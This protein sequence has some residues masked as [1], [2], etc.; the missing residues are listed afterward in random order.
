MRGLPLDD[1][2]FEPSMD[3]FVGAAQGAL[4][5]MGEELPADAAW[6]LSGL[7]FGAQVHRTL[8]PEGLFPRAWD[9]T[10]TKV[11]E[12]FGYGCIAGLRDFFYTEDDISLLRSGWMRNIRKHLDEGLPAIAF[13]LHGPAFGIVHGFDEDKEAYLVSTRFDGHKDE[14]VH[15]NDLGLVD[16]PRV[17]VLIPTGSLS[18]YDRAAAAREALREAP[19]LLAGKQAEDAPPVPPDLAVGPDACEAWAAALEARRVTPPWGAAYTAAYYVEA[20]T[21]AAAFL[22][23]AAKAWLP[24]LAPGLEEAALDMD[25][26]ARGLEALAGL[27]PV[28]EPEALENPGRIAEA[29]KLLNGLR[30]EMAVSQRR[31]ERLGQQLAPPPEPTKEA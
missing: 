6:G 27:F 14:P 17:F 1:V 20:R 11:M 26:Q 7:A 18:K 2:R 3:S 5:A 23:R 21:N 28:R 25:R 8:A 31:L 19:A 29:R 30:A 22:R 12:R 13:G 16:P 10:Y 15:V 24:Q 4:R 9:V